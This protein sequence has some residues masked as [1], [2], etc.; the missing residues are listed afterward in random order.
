MLA[1]EDFTV[2]RQFQLGPRR[3]TTEEIIAFAEEFDP[4]PFHLDGDSE[5]A[6]QTG[7]LI[8]SGWHICGLFM[9]MACEAFINN[10]LSDG[11]PGV[12]EVRWMKPLRPRDTLSGV[13]TV[14]ERRVSRS[15]PSRGF[16]Q[17]ETN[18]TNQ[19]GETIASLRYP[20]MVRLRNPENFSDDAAS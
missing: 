16:V 7:G 2:G 10:S 14:G 18:L 5:Q 12:E 13:V 1:Y 9:A 20:A 6:R 15:R 19:S 8:A 11:A 17:F 3:V 4:Q